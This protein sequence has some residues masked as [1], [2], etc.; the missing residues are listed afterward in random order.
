Y[1]PP[2][3]AAPELLPQLRTRT[4]FSWSIVFYH[5]LHSHTST[6][7][8]SRNTISTNERCRISC[9]RVKNLAASA[10]ENIYAISDAELTLHQQVYSATVEHVSQA[11]GILGLSLTSF[12]PFAT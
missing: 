11:K 6:R 5:G 3:H 10:D 4:R 9:C 12:N 7:P 2:V 1:Y 8:S